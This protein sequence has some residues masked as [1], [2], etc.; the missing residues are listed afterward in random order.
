MGEQWV[1]M[2]IGGNGTMTRE[3]ATRI[4]AEKRSQNRGNPSIKLA[5]KVA[6]GPQGYM[7]LMKQ[8][9]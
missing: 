9:G 6:K 5:F 8:V 7:V 2:P 4:A 3:Q 1:K